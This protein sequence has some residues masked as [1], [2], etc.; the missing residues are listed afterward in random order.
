MNG[1]NEY[2]LVKSIIEKYPKMSYSARKIRYILWK[3]GYDINHN[4]INHILLKMKN[5]GYIKIF[6]ETKNKVIYI[7]ASR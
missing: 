4:K 5:E 7:K 2:D 1:I 3:Q 6:K